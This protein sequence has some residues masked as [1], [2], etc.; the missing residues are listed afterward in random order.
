MRDMTSLDVLF[1]I[2]ELRNLIGGQIQKVY[3]SG[4]AVWF[5][6]FLPAKGSFTLRFGPGKIFITEYKRAAP[7]IP[8]NFAMFCRKHVQGQRVTDVRQH[9]FDRIVEFETEKAVI[10]FE[11]FSKGNVIV[12]DKAK[13]ILMPLD[14]QIW[15]DRRIV[16]RSPYTYPPE[17]VNPFKLTQ[18]ELYNILA[19]SSK[20]LVRLLAVDL[21]LSGLYA[22]EVCARAQIDKNKLCRNV[23]D[24]ET[25]A[26]YEAIHSLIK[27]FEPRLV[28][29]DSKIVD[30][31]PFEM[32]VYK[33]KRVEKISTFMHALDEAFTREA[34]G[35]AEI[36]S[37]K[38]TGG[39]LAKLERIAD[40]QRT[41]IEKL[42]QKTEDSRTK[43]EVIIKNIDMV[44]KI[45]NGLHAAR[46]AGQNWAQIKKQVGAP[47]KEIRERKGI[48]RVEL[49]SRDRPYG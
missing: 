45:I 39:K 9:G 27:Q 15:K 31:V 47:I 22:E 34:V 8:E 38:V 28:F 16:P 48:V 13:K 14:V 49:S 18:A 10:I 23:N 29:E 21:S 2:N 5:E 33:N 26:V 40:E 17:V 12:C 6:V 42:K 44:E 3:Q 30:A 1:A 4:K 19:Q 32:I 35:E 43:A 11:M 7:E 46:A 41:A 37:T 20:D 36:E 24:N 25:L